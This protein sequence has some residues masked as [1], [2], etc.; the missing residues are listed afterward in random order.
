MPL[1]LDQEA[2]LTEPPEVNVLMV[3]LGSRDIVKKIVVL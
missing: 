3:V 2:A 1:P